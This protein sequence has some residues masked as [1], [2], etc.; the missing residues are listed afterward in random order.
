VQGRADDSDNDKIKNNNSNDNNKDGSQSPLW[1]A[2]HWLAWLG[3]GRVVDGE[4][5]T[6]LT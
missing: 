3:L 1:T 5:G 6:R 2:S 4:T